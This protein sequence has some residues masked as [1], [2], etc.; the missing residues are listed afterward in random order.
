MQFGLPRYTNGPTPASGTWRNS[1]HFN[2]NANSAKGDE[3]SNRYRYISDE[4][5]FMMAFAMH[6]PTMAWHHSPL[7]YFIFGSCHA[8][9]QINWIIVDI[10][11]PQIA[12][13]YE[14]CHSFFYVLAHQ[15][16]DKNAIELSLPKCHLNIAFRTG[17]RTGTQT[18]AMFVVPKEK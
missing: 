3:T 16:S 1:K 18:S 5:S 11:T 8:E 2:G 10:V 9:N 15:T 17:T 6:C 13:A 12:E 7:S 4:W 14:L